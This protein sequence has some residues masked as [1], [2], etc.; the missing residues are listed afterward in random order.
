MMSKF[1]LYFGDV[2]NAQEAKMIFTEHMTLQFEDLC[3][4]GVFED[5]PEMYV[6]DTKLIIVFDAK[7]TSHVM[8]CLGQIT[9]A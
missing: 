5:L 9:T 2:Q 3:E 6:H 1:V 8:R 4:Q 7:Q